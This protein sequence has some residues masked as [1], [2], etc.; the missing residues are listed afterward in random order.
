MFERTE[1]L[2][3]ISFRRLL[4]IENVF[5]LGDL[6]VR[7]A[8]CGRSGVRAI[9]LDAPWERNLAM[10]HE[11]RFS[12]Y[13]L[14]E[15]NAVRPV[16]IIHVKDLFLRDA[17]QP[18]TTEQLKSLARPCAQM[19]E[20]LPVE[21]A[22]PRFQRR[23]D[24]M[25]VV[26]G[27][28]GEWMGIITIE[29]ML[30]EVVGRIGDEFDQA[31]TG[32]FIS[33]ADALSPGRIVLGLHAQ[34]MREAIDEIIVRISPSELPADPQR[35]ARV[36]LE[37]EKAVPTFLGKGLAVP[38]GCF[39]GLDRP[40]L[41]FARSDQGVPVEGSNERAKLFFSLLPPS[42]MARIQPRLLAD[43]VGLFDS[44]Y[45][46]ERLRKA[47]TPEEV[48]EAISAGLDVAID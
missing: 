35:I 38:H 31:R 43:I 8:M 17:T 40:M 46:T 6:K 42:G 47:K 28:Q 11:T 23:F 13:P 32:R 29:D 27:A 7:N 30:E 25:G 20:D 41:A 10:I 22:L 45:V 18:M 1:R 37:R 36:V 12:R 34:S 3:L 24:Q 48:M 16:G 15:S 21:E 4:L 19:S 2:G 5:D 33:L 39:A 44:E 14:I 9:D 26:F